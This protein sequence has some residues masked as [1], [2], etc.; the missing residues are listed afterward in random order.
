MRRNPAKKATICSGLNT[1]AKVRPLTAV[2]RNVLLK[3]QSR[4]FGLHA[5]VVCHPAKLFVVLFSRDSDLPLEFRYSRGKRGGG[6][7]VFRREADLRI[8]AHVVLVMSAQKLM[9]Q[10]SSQ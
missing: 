8:T 6:L 2:L 9:V 5:C 1:K 10:D 3:R 4:L 7:L